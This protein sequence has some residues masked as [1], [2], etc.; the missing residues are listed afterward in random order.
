MAQRIGEQMRILPAVEAES[1]FIQIGLQMFR[2]DLVPRSDDAALKQ[3]ERRLDSVGMNVAVNVYFGLVLDGLMLALECGTSERGRIGVEFI[4]HD[5]VNVLTNR[6]SDVLRQCAS[7]NVCGVEESQIAA[8]LS[9]ANNDLFFGVS[10]SG[11]AVA[12]LTSTNVCFVYLN[13]AVH[14]GP[15]YFFHGVP[16]SMAEVPCGFVADPQRALDL[17]SA[18]ALLRD[19]Q[20]VC[21][22]E[23]FQEGQ[24]R[25]IEYGASENGELVTTGPAVVLIP[26]DDAREI[27]GSLAP[28]AGSTFRPAQS[29]KIGA[30]L[31]FSSEFFHN[32][33]KV[34]VQ[35]GIS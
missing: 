27:S 32:F 28:W 35:H 30:A 20:Q 3:R 16:D 15:V 4:G 18:H 14:H 1:H 24:V 12:F 6:L 26:L 17:F 13:G 2:A 31:V 11:L 7:L 9:D 34:G 22:D 5:Y 21:S 23:P 33:E 29:L 8:A 25:V 10:E 19:T